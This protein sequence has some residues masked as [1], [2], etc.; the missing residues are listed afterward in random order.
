MEVLRLE[1]NCVSLEVQPHTIHAFYPRSSLPFFPFS[2]NTIHPAIITTPG[3]ACRFISPPV[4]YI[5]QMPKPAHPASFHSPHPAS[6]HPSVPLS[7]PLTR[8]QWPGRP[9]MKESYNPVPKPI[10]PCV[11]PALTPNPSLTPPLLSPLPPPLPRLRLCSH[12]RLTFAPARLN[13]LQFN[14]SIM[15]LSAGAP[16]L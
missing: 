5:H 11:N 15:E 8:V 13:R 4:I 1:R 3:Y 10:W 9:V 12:L 2:L 14:I 7:L 6:S 16:H